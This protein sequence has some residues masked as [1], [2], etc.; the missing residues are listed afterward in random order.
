[1][2]S[3][4]VIIHKFSILSPWSRLLSQLL[5]YIPI[6]SIYQQN[7]ALF[8]K[9]GVFK[10][11]QA[12][13]FATNNLF[14]VV[15][16]VNSDAHTE[17]GH[18]AAFV[19]ENNTDSAFFHF[20]VKSEVFYVILRVVQNIVSIESFGQILH[21]TEVQPKTQNID[22][23]SIQIKCGSFVINI[24]VKKL[25]PLGLIDFIIFLKYLNFVE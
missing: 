1:M 19:H 16:V 7:I 4:F 18:D 21:Q 11:L 10:I 14:A 22:S 8:A 6:Y 25:S 9:D 23:L 24:F 15:A 20:H 13:A 3:L 2:L 12:L 17:F 5:L